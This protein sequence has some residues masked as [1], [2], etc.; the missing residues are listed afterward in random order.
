M[1]TIHN[2]SHSYTIYVVHA[3][4]TSRISPKVCGIWKGFLYKSCMLWRSASCSNVYTFFY[5]WSSFGDFKDNCV[6]L[7]INNVFPVTDR[8]F[9][10]STIKKS[11]CLPYT[12]VVCC[13][14][15]CSCNCNSYFWCVDMYIN[16]IYPN[17]LFL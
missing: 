5:R 10:S 6:I 7:N 1:Y 13:S 17:G 4:C 2:Y 15:I 14:F 12:I 3:N 16:F 9:E 8:F 11:I